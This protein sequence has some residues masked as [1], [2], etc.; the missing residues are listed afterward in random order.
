MLSR[1]TSE[2]SA[3]DV[4]ANDSAVW[5]LGIRGIEYSVRK[6]SHETP[7]LES[8]LQLYVWSEN[9][10]ISA[11]ERKFHPRALIGCSFNIKYI[12]QH[13]W[14]AYNHCACAVWLFLSTSFS[15]KTIKRQFRNGAYLLESK[16][17]CC[18]FLNIGSW[19]VSMV[20]RRRPAFIK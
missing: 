4:V 10:W 9:C 6:I 18:A 16:P 11:T 3:P 8:S 1:Q 17:F 15:V 7:L 13:T 19:L 20:L 12:I 14:A 2:G 5:F